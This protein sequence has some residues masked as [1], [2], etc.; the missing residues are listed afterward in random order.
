MKWWPFHRARHPELDERITRAQEER[1]EVR[2]MRPET[3]RLARRMDRHLAENHFAERI[4][5]ALSARKRQA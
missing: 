1:A 3:E 5:A 4:T 2:A